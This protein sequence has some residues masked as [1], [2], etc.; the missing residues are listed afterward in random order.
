MLLSNIGAEK[1]GREGW[2]GD[3]FVSTLNL[4]TILASLYKYIPQARFNRQRK[5]TNGFSKLQIWFDAV[6]S[7]PVV[8]IWVLTA[9]RELW[10]GGGPRISLQWLHFVCSIGSSAGNGW[11]L[12]QWWKYRGGGNVEDGTQ[13]GGDEAGERT[14]LI[15][16]GT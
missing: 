12:W 6:A 16:R 5:S 4:V 9:I 7:L 11:L 10:G 3:D 8:A 2:S 1:F 13:F 14:P 15:T